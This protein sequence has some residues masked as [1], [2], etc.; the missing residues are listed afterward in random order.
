MNNDPLQH[1]D[2]LCGNSAATR[3]LRAGIAEFAAEQ[4]QFY[5]RMQDPAW[6]ASGRDAQQR[7]PGRGLLTHFLT[8]A[9][10]LHSCSNTRDSL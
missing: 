10:V 2:V 8:N 3:A 4:A 6:A 9:P 7:F 1:I 5:L